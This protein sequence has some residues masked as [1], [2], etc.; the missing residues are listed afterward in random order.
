MRAG[1]IESPL[2]EIAFVVR[3]GRLTALEFTGRREG[4]APAPETADVAARLEAY[5]Q[6]DLDALEA[7]ETDA[8]GT[9]FQRL[10]W[11]ELRR[12]PVGETRSYKEIARAIGRPRAVR[13]V[14]AANG[15][16][17]IGIVVPCHRV[18]GADG[19]LTGYAGGIER[20]RWLLE[21]EGALQTADP[22]AKPVDQAA[23]KL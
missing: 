17:P 8:G 18:I 1:R 3:D 9:E 12:I 21:H 11:R 7:I 10:V 20:K 6:G 19:S 14:G 15:Q 5:F 23:W 22:A 13:A 16:N 2:G 4:G